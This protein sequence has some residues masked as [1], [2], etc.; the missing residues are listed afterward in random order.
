MAFNEATTDWLQMFVGTTGVQRV[1]ER[2]AEQMA[3]HDTEDVMA[4]VPYPCRS[5]NVI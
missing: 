4:T 2:T 5:S 1:A 3:A